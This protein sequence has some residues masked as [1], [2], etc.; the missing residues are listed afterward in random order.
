MTLKRMFLA[1]IIAAISM[2]ALADQG[3]T[4]GYKNVVKPDP[5]LVEFT[6]EIRRSWMSAKLFDPSTRD[7]FFAPDVKTFIKTE[8]PFQPFEPR[9]DITSDYL[10]N[11]VPIM[12]ARKGEEVPKKDRWRLAHGALAEIGRQVTH[13]PVWGTLPE[14]PGMICAGAAFDVDQ[15]AVAKFSRMHGVRIDELVL[16]KQA[17]P[18]YASKTM[19]SDFL[20]DVPPLTLIVIGKDD[21]AKEDWHPIIASNGIKGYM[22]NTVVLEKLAQKHVCFTKVYGEYRISALFGYGL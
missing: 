7:T 19:K 6:H 20:G 22:G 4:V 21:V 8:T 16:S 18:I 14:V 2:P 10:V 17:I 13:N 5:E 11:A 1:A 15:R 9:D 3:I 12:R